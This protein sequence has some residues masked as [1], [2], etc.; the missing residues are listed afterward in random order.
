MRKYLLLAAAAFIAAPAA[1]RAA[2]NAWGPTPR[3]DT[4]TNVFGLPLDEVSVGFGLGNY[5]A[6]FAN[7]VGAGSSWNLGADL[8]ITRPL[9][10]EV[11][12]VGGINSLQ[13][14]QSEFNAYTNGI[15]AQLQLEPWTWDDTFTPYVSGGVG[16]NRISVAKNPQLNR[17]FQSDTAGAIPLAAGLDIQVTD[18]IIAGARAQYDILFDNEVIVGENSTDSDRTSFMLKLGTSAF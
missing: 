16:L 18:D 15:Q 11:N 17:D 6:D 5:T 3:A 2:E 1:V 4:T 13:G 12:Y 14:D 9:D 8:D 7:D 10:L